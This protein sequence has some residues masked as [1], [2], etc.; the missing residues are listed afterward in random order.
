MKKQYLVLVIV[1]IFSLQL[2][3]QEQR[4][5]SADPLNLIVRN[6]SET[7]NSAKK[8]VG[9]IQYEDFSAVSKIL[10]MEKDAPALP[11]F[12]K[13]LQ[14]PNSGKVALEISYDSFEEFDAIEILPS[15]GSLKR[16][17][18]PNSIPFVM[19]ATYQQDAF[20]PGNLAQLG[21]SFVFRN[22][23]GITVSFYP[24]QYN[25]VTKKMRVYKNI[26]A[27][28]VTNS[29]E[30]GMN[31][32]TS[33]T[34][35]NTSVFN[36]L[37]S[38]LYL[39]SVNNVAYNP[40]EDEGEMLIIAPTTGYTSV[41]QNFINWKSEKGIRTTL[42]TLAQT[43]STPEAIKTYI[44]N[45]Y[46]THPNLVYIQLVGD[47]ENVP[48]HSYGITG[49][50]EQLWSD[51]YY[52]MLEG[53]DY[54][55]ELIVGRFSG[56]VVDV[57]TMVQRTIEYETSPLAGDWMKKAIGIGSNE[58][59][60]YGDDGE[61]DWQHLRNIGTKLTTF[62]Y[63]TIHEFYEGTHGGNDLPNNPTSQMISAAINQ[64]SGL[65]NY[66]GHGW[67]EGVSTGDYTNSDVQ[68]LTNSGKYPFM[69]S[70]ACNN[71]TFAGSTSLC[72]AFTRVKYNGTPAGAIASCGSSILMAW[73]E[74]MQTQ[75]EMTELIIRSD[76][77]NIKSTLGGLFYNG[78]ISMLET[79]NQSN[80]SEEVMQTW[81]FF[82]D[83]ST[84]F[85]SQVPNSITGNHE[86]SISISGGNLEIISNTNG[87]FVS[88]TQ[89]NVTIGTGQ[90]VNNLATIQVPTLSSTD[91]LKVTI[92][93]ENTIP[94]RGEVAVNALG[95]TEFEKQLVVYPNPASDVLYISNSGIS[96]A[97]ATIQIFDMN[98][99]IIFKESN[100]NVFTNYSI[101]VATLASGLYLI[102]INDGS[103]RKVQKIE[104]R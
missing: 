56:S 59:D 36:S 40:I 9:G 68:T 92:S 60:G 86:E 66:T 48:T 84:V 79:Y 17:I 63:N 70:V 97:D 90:I 42:A 6:T 74:P 37:Y 24:Y 89:N 51:S 58:G 54:F 69:I 98:G 103:N 64:G 101:P 57:Q 31:E 52:G 7:Y 4:L 15:K 82:G 45:Y 35:E 22:T 55:P 72:E 50:Q 71:G 104:I 53:D 62:G 12:S 96:I 91:V 87:A 73:A 93:K 102:D 10:M 14:L 100:V 43:G 44:Q 85:R 32:R 26:T 21:K 25:P 77:Q 8:N 2:F 46:A 76:V 23:R 18:D 80:T 19:G 41:L 13:S 33:S 3:A 75:D 94:Y 11:V 30:V 38:N 34:Q 78:Q 99:R 20:F 81:V 67:T 29:S 88:I 27:Q 39:N 1:F 5:V 47:H 95:L 83:P 49:A 16:N 65:L 28:I 61:P